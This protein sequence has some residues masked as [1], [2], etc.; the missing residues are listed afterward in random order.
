MYVIGI[1]NAYI[2][3]LAWKQKKKKKQKQQQQKKSWSILVGKAFLLWFI[4]ILLNR[5]SNIEFICAFFMILAVVVSA[6]TRSAHTNCISMSE[7]YKAF[8][9]QAHYF[10]QKQCTCRTFVVLNI[11]TYTW[12]IFAAFR[13]VINFME[14][15]RATQRGEINNRNRFTVVFTMFIHRWCVCAWII[16]TQPV[17]SD[18]ISTE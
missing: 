15:W 6:Y 18:V 4:W 12:R 8:F 5:G 11:Y 3:S 2:Y 13:F 17:L 10:L 14:K 9:K 1:R 16:C 7:G